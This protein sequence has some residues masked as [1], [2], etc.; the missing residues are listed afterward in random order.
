LSVFF[1]S[2]YGEE[3]EWIERFLRE[4]DIPCHFFYNEVSNSFLHM[5]R[6]P[7]PGYFMENL[8]IPDSVHVIT[9]MSPNKGKDIGGKLILMDAYMRLG[10]KSDYILLLHDKKSPFHVKGDKWKEDL[11]RIAKK[12]NLKKAISLFTEHPKIGIIASENAIRNEADND[13]GN[14][15][16]INSDIITKIK[17]KYSIYPPG[18]QYVAGTMYFV[19]S[20]LFE[21]FFRLHSPLEIRSSLEPG[22]V[23][24]EN[25]PT[26]THSWERLLSWIVTSKGYKIKGI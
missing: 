19:R 8:S 10:L 3:K 20:R 2:Y 4:I 16:Y 24:D 25:R 26:I 12:E 11:F 9:R 18:L 21:D 13:T 14:N 6:A 1:H 22:N 7:S 5:A 15:F 17:D 23:T